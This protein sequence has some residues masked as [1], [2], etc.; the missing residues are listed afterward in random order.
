M[1]IDRDAVRSSSV[2]YRYADTVRW[3]QI[4][5]VFWSA[6]R[7]HRW[8]R[9]GN[10]GYE[11]AKKFIGAHPPLAAKWLAGTGAENAA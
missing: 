3:E 11:A 2:W 8:P 5:L 10:E 6:S 7:P 9:Y 1:L 4:G